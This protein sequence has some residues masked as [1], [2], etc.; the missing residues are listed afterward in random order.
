MIIYENLEKNINFNNHFN[1]S[2]FNF[3]LQIIIYNYLYLVFL[4]FNFSLSIL[5]VESHIEA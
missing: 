5:K 4:Y 3:I 2:M 1:A